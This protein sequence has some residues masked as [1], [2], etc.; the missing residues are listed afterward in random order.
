[1]ANV[2]LTR[3]PMA[4]FKVCTHLQHNNGRQLLSS[5]ANRIFDVIPEVVGKHKLTELKLATTFDP[6]WRQNFLESHQIS[7]EAW[8]ALLQEDHRS[9]IEKRMATLMALERQ[10]MTEKGVTPPTSTEPALS[11]IDVEDE[12]PLND[13]MDT[14]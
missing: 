4:L 14:E 7:Q 8:T 1:M 9:F 3:G 10:F 2:V 12:V 11:A 13:D 5:P 6:G